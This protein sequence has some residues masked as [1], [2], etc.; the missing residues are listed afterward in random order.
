MRKPSQEEQS[1]PTILWEPIKPNWG[2]RCRAGCA[3]LRPFRGPA[4]GTHRAVSCRVVLTLAS[5][6]SPSLPSSRTWADRLAK[7][8]NLPI[9]KEAPYSSIDGTGGK[10]DAKRGGGE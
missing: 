9:F 4:Q 2:W 7:K 6:F 5:L 1:G 10:E 3:S 8:R